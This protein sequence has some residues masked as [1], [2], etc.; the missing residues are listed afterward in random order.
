[1]CPWCL[2]DDDKFP[3]TDW[4]EQAEWRKLTPTR[5]WRN[6][7]PLHGAPGG[8]HENILVKDLFHLCNLGAVRTFC[9]NLLC[10][11]TWLG[12]FVPWLAKP[13]F[14]LTPLRL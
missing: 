8:G 12:R 4:R 10:Y 7:S 14:D 1:M 3:Y 13:G 11:L 2:A 6:P 5:P 9:V